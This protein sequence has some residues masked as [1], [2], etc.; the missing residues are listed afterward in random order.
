MYITTHSV[1]LW[2][3]SPDNGVFKPWHLRRWNPQNNTIYTRILFVIKVQLFEFF[4]FRQ[5]SW[6]YT[7]CLGGFEIT[8]RHITLGNTP[9]DKWSARRTGLYLT[10]HND[11]KIQTSM[12]PAE[13]EPAI[14]LSEQPQ[15]HVLH[16]AATGIGN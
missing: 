7:S 3:G 16:C 2:L 12:L 15:T 5:P 13:F 14:P 8:L 4:V 10:T 9:L 11:D 1:F 6:I